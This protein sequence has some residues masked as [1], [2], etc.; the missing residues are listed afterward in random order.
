MT[1]YNNRSSPIISRVQYSETQSDDLTIDFVRQLAKNSVQPKSQVDSLHDTMY[2]I[3]NGNKPRYPSVDA[4]IKDMMDRTG[5]TTYKQQLQADQQAQAKIATLK[6]DL[7]DKVPQIKNT[8]DNYI[9]STRGNLL[10][11]EILSQIKSIHRDDVPDAADWGSPT[12]LTY[13]NEKNISEKKMHPDFMASDHDLGKV[14]YTEDDIDPSNT[15]ALHVLNP[16]VV[17]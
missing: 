7:F 12:L 15:D 2:S 16:A 6:V 5:I 13:I 10:V 1:K 14:N 17:K 9:Q 3:I 4:A 8:I 11:P